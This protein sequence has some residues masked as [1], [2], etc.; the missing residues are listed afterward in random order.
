[1]GGIYFASWEINSQIVCVDSMGEILFLKRNFVIFTLNMRET[2]LLSKLICSRMVRPPRKESSSVSVPF[3]SSCSFPGS[4][5]AVMRKA[6]LF[7]LSSESH[8]FRYAT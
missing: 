6:T 2:K 7:L 1:M 5:G 8:H 4:Q 3:S